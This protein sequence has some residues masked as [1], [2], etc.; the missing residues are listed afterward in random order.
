MID[1]DA[2][3]EFWTVVLGTRLVK[4]PNEATV[5][6]EELRFGTTLRSTQD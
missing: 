3:Y 5:W 6:P 1:Y 4:H 2:I